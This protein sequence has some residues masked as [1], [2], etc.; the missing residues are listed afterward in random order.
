MFTMFR[1]PIERAVS[2]FHYLPKAKHEPTYDPDL[3][4]ISIEMWSRSKRVEHNWMTRFL[5]NE[6]EADLTLE[7]LEISKE[8]LRKKCIIGLFDEKSESWL[9]L[10]RFFRWKFPPKD[11]RECLDRLLNWGWSNKNLHPTVEEGSDAWELLY[12]QNEFDMMLYQHAQ[13]L[14]EQQRTLFGE[15]GILV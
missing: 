11:N 1:H 13:L 7:H 14:F 6:L 10:E 12:K 5:S 4:H 3:S 8:V 2:M 15:G 9:R